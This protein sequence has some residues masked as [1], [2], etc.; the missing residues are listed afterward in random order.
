[1]EKRRT[2]DEDWSAVD[3]E[4]EGLA[5]VAAGQRLPHQSHP[6]E[7]HPLAHRRGRIARA[8]GSSLPEVHLLGGA[9]AVSGDRM[10][11]TASRHGWRPGKLSFKWGRCCSEPISGYKAQH[12][13]TL[14]DAGA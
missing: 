12:K 1:M 13:R 2:F 11:C 7:A 8:V 5:L 6:L 9:R 4:E 14:R 3:L 10:H